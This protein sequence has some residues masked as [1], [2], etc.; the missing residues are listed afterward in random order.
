MANLQQLQQQIDNLKRTIASLG[1]EGRGFRTLLENIEQAA[2]A[3][4]DL[5]NQVRAFNQLEEDV[6]KTQR[7]INNE[8]GTTFGIFQNINSELTRG[9]ST[10]NKINKATRSLESISSKLLNRRENISKLSAKELKKLKEISDQ[11]FTDLKR[12]QEFLK[13]K[14]NNLTPK[15]LKSLE[16]INGILQEN[17]G[18]QSSFNRQLEASIK[19]QTAIENSLG[20]TGAVL[21]TITQIPGLSSLSQYLN[22]DKAISSV[23][24]YN[25]ELI[26]AVKESDEFAIKFTNVNKNIQKTSD[27]ISEIDEKLKDSNLTEDEKN[28]LLKERE[29]LEN[30]LNRSVAYRAELEEEATEKALGGLNKLKSAFKGITELGKGFAKSIS[31]PAV[32]MGAITKSFLE[33]NKANREV[34]Q[35]TGQTATNF[36]SFN[37]SIVSSTDQVKTIASLSKQLGINVNAAF[38]KD[39][40]LA[41]TELTELLGLSAEEAAKLSLRTEAFGQDL[42]KVDDDTASIVSNFNKNNRSAVNF[43]DVLKDSASASGQLATTIGKTPGALENAAAA[44]R[45]LG[46]SLSEVEGIADN[47]L[48]FQSSIEAEMEAE[49]LTGKQINLERARSA[50]LMNDME[51]LSKEIG[52]NEAVI[53]A[54]ST[55]NRIEQQ[56]IAKAMGVT[57]EQM[58]KMYFTQLKNKDLT[59]EQIAQAM[60]ISL[61]EAKRL[62]VQEQLSKSVEKLTAKF[63]PLLEKVAS[64]ADNSLVL[65]GTLGLVGAI[66]FASLI[67]SLRVIKSLEIASSIAKIFGGNAKFGPAGIALAAA[68]VGAMIGAIATYALKGDDVMSPGDGSGYGKRT[69]MGP[70][71]AIALNNKDT[72]IAGTNLFGGGKEKM[73]APQNNNI[74]PQNNNISID[75]SPLVER[76]SAVENVLIQILNK[77]GDVYMDGAKVGKSLTLATSKVG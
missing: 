1:S 30:R 60:N 46:L 45:K 35:I 11:R 71:G 18:L 10:I 77:E 4:G 32:I 65:Y 36:S 59:D 57:T 8:L 17:V 15:E 27:S 48:N 58:S 6:L 76:M 2:Q 34:R 56:A 9:S 16:E 21:K 26:D 29:R 64:L 33:F 72:V 28:E 51:T 42:G 22:I 41:A 39:T 75:I 38:S 7:E 3:G 52:S 37:D 69:L 44:S 13:A 49:L 73:E 20:I 66:Q 55:G 70:E 50:A 24:E 53:N 23:E 62:D 40:I 5:N 14:G 25:K 31:D 74:S 67:K 12:E 61:E 19:E 54:F 63:S 43:Q 68:G 47:L